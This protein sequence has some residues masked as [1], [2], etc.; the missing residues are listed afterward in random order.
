M[1][2]AVSSVEGLLTYQWQFNGA[3]LPGQTNHLLVLSNAQP[4]QAGAYSVI[5]SNGLAEVGRAT[6]TLAVRVPVTNLFNTGVN[7][8]GGG[9]D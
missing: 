1:W 7:A 6:N 2:L 8:Q 3:S 5:I 9:A 4:S